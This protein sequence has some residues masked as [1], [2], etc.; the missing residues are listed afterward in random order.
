MIP[1]QAAVPLG[2]RSASATRRAAMKM[3]ARDVNVF[4]GD[5]QALFDVDLDIPRDAGHRPDRPVR[6]RQVDLPALPQPH[7]RHHR[8]L[9]RDRRDRARRQRHLRP[10]ARRRASCAPASAWCSRSRTRS[11]SRSSRTSPTARASTAWPAAR[12][13]CDD[14]VEQ[15]PEA[16]RPVGRG[17]GPAGPS[18]APACP[19]ASSSACASPAP[20]PSAR[21]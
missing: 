3:T 13:S 8:Q 19:A 21:R 1:W 17:Q 20:S 11:R 10:R 6:L 15:Q 5:K 18:P 12:P 4:Y 2:R 9:P 7:E 16:G 14:I